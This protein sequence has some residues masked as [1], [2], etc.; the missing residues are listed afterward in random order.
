MSVMHTDLDELITMAGAT[1]ESEAKLRRAAAALQGTAVML[2]DPSLD[3]DG[4]EVLNKVGVMPH[5]IYWL[6]DSIS[7][8]SIC[9]LDDYPLD[10]NDEDDEEEDMPSQTP[11]F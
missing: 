6:F 5:D 1:V 10:D 2:V 4:I 9:N 11:L 3:L 7:S 8:H